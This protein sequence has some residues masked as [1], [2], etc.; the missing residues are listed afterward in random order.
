MR[1]LLLLFGLGTN[2]VARKTSRIGQ[3]YL[4]SHAYYC[5]TVLYIAGMAWVTVVFGRILTT[6]HTTTVNH[7][8]FFVIVPVFFFFFVI[9]F[10][11][12]VFGK[13]V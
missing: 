1:L 2:T 13:I 12:N 10:I 4:Y 3:N 6:F 8:F 11:W 9:F 7:Y 5:I